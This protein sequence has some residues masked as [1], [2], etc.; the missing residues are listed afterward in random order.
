MSKSPA[1]EELVQSLARDLGIQNHVSGNTVGL[2]L[3]VELERDR[4]KC[5]QTGP[6]LGKWPELISV[7]RACGLTHK[8]VSVF[9]GNIFGWIRLP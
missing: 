6:W 8:D 7:R 3:W 1:R 4:P 9:A 5:C 2:K